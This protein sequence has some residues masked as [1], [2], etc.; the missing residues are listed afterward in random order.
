[1]SESGGGGGSS[2]KSGQS[3]IRTSPRIISWLTSS[4]AATGHCRPAGRPN[5]TNE[6]LQRWNGQTERLADL[7]ARRFASGCVVVEIIL[8][9]R[10]HRFRLETNPIH[11]LAD[12]GRPSAHG[13]CLSGAK[14]SSQSVVQCP[15]ALKPTS[16]QTITATTT[17]A[18][19]TAATTTSETM[20]RNPPMKRR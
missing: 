4:E 14:A 7:S 16:A 11:R 9:P 15:R 8:L 1:M 19:T 12:S 13:T 6:R 3:V 20:E 5:G 18:A 17:T 2:S 10:P